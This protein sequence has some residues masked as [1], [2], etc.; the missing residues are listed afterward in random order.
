MDNVM[1][2]ILSLA[3]GMLSLGFLWIYKSSKRRLV[4]VEDELKF[5]KQEKEYYDEA[6]MVLSENYDI[7]YANQ[8]A[9]VLFSLNENNIAMNVGKTVELKTDTSR[10]DEFFKVLMKISEGKADSFHLQN[11]LL[12][13]S[14]KMKQ[15]NIYVD[16]SASNLN[17]TITCIIDMQMITPEEANSVTDKD[18]GGMDFLTGLPSQFSAL[19]DINSLIVESKNKSESF[20][21]F[22]LGIDYFNDIQ[23]TLGLRYT[24]RIFKSL[25]QYFIDNP[26]NNMKLYRM[27][28]D[29]FLF[30]IK[31]INEEHLAHNTARD[32]II[33]VKN[34]YKDNND[35]RL[36]SSVGISLYPKDAENASKL[37]DN[38]YIALN[39]AQMQ[40]ESNIE[41]FN[42]EYRAVHL[43][44]VKMNEEI[45]KGLKNNEF[46]L[47]Y[48][49]IFDL[50]GEKMIGAEALIRWKHPEHGLITADKFLSVADKT[51][52][53]VDLG[54]YVFNEAIKQRER[55]QVSSEKNF[56]ITINLSLKE[57]DVK[58][59]I[60]RLEVLFDKHKVDRS[61][62]NLDI[63]ESV[64]MENID[65]TVRDLKLLK[66]FGLSLSLD[67]FGAGYSSFKYLAILPI[68]MIKIDRAFIFDLSL[69][70]NHQKTVKS[71]IYLAH[72]LG[73][74]VVAEGVETSQEASILS[75]MKCDYAQGYLYS[76]PLPA[77]DFEELL[78]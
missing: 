25:A 28:G 57:M 78:K 23:T 26:Q 16:K 32:L 44:E 35:M 75:V 66:D 42:N 11:V 62:I 56:Q 33:S 65:K 14:G 52:L 24:N 55:L 74:K 1:V 59:L 77:L 38:A 6:M 17:K 5:F 45:R 3:L 36:T 68:D 21:L 39:K 51:G 2:I 76:R 50:A 64:A 10:P 34:I 61:T 48:Q 53:I 29:K 13:I 30:L 22:L 18:D 46:L 4:V 67:H 31:H 47:H 9:K 60:P 40:N 54:V 58:E 49:P 27:E 8:A 69:S 41:V 19:S 72:T 71:M 63:S 43:D 12:V 20:G 70:L 7:V 73:Y 37:I 15:V